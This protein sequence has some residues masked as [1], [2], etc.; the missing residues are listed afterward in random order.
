[1]GQTNIMFRGIEGLFSSAMFVAGFLDHE[2]KEFLLA[3]FAGDD[4][5]FAAPRKSQKLS[6]VARKVEFM[7]RGL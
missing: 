1:M 6:V 3:T 4:T 5:I 7:L 2:C